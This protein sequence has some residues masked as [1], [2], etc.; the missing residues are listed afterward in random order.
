MRTLVLTTFSFFPPPLHTGSESWLSS[1]PGAS[2][3][4]CFLLEERS[5]GPFP[6]VLRADEMH[7]KKIDFMIEDVGDGYRTKWM[8][9]LN[10]TELYTYKWWTW[11]ILSQFLWKRQLEI[12]LILSTVSLFTSL[13]SVENRHVLYKTYLDGLGSGP[14]FLSLKRTNWGNFHNSLKP[15][16][17]QLR[18]EDYTTSCPSGSC[19]LIRVK[20]RQALNKSAAIC[21][22]NCGPQKPLRNEILSRGWLRRGSCRPTAMSD[23]IHLLPRLLLAVRYRLCSIPGDAPQSHACR[24]HSVQSFYS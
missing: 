12:T 18:N 15:P 4:L 10:L 22:K 17:P 21:R 16:F 2:L 5:P 8:N 3:T 11:S 24:G 13:L 19:E 7:R 14:G 20:G 9:V 6:R 1:L 23:V